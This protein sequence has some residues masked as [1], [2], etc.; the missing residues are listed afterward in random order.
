M[1]AVNR[2]ELIK[3]AEENIKLVLTRAKERNRHL[4]AEEV[5]ALNV[6]VPLVGFPQ[7]G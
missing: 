6:L 7:G 1:T 3:L 4:T 2:I 5:A